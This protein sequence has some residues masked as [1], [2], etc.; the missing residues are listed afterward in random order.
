MAGGT[1]DET[2]ERFLVDVD[3]E[4]LRAQAL[5]ALVDAALG[6]IDELGADKA[7]PLI[8][9][10][11]LRAMDCTT[12]VLSLVDFGRDTLESVAGFD[13]SGV[14]TAVRGSRSLSADPTAARVIGE[15]EPLFATPDPIAA[16]SAQVL[17]PA[18]QIEGGWLAL[19]LL[20]QGESIGM[21]ELL[22]GHRERRY[23]AGELVLAQGVCAS[24]ARAV[25]ES[26]AFAKFR[27]AATS[28]SDGEGGARAGA[29]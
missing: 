24:I 25:A 19:P 10:R 16:D 1:R 7:L 20:L 17:A 5:L 27:P 2:A 22:A 4:K 3:Q 28:V 15:R 18:A 13:V 11:L 23:T 8:C 29:A 12:A 6:A 14:R 26:P 21:I 9:A